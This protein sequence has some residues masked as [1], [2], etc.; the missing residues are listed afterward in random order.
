MIDIYPCNHPHLSHL[1][2]EAKEA[3]KNRRILDDESWLSSSLLA[4]IK[5]Q[6]PNEERRLLLLITAV[7]SKTRSSHRKL[8]PGE[9]FDTF[10]VGT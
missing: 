6:P 4:S 10:N 9:A 8:A 2:S 5:N 1:I 7:E 3:K